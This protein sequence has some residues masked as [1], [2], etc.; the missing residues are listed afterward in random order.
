MLFFA[1]FTVFLLILVHL[2]LFFVQQIR[3]FGDSL[4]RELRKN[5]AS[6][7]RRISS[8]AIKEI[9][10]VYT[11]QEEIVQLLTAANVYSFITARNKSVKSV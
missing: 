7:H 5:Q 11:Q 1:S 6:R 2:H 4:V 8:P 3:I 9:H 10:I